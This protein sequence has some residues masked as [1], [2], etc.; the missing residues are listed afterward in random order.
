M[1]KAYDKS[2]FGHALVLTDL[3]QDKDT[4][5]TPPYSSMD[6]TK[7]KYRMRKQLAKIKVSV[8]V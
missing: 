4:Q 1:K 8:Y 6:L 2:F 3:L 7:E 5:T